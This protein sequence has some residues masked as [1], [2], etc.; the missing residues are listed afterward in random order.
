[1]NI[2]QWDAVILSVESGNWTSGLGLPSLSSV[3]LGHH[4]WTGCGAHSTFYYL[5]LGAF[6]GVKREKL[7]TL[8]ECWRNDKVEMYLRFPHVT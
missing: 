3:C 5:V 7:F 2:K 8:F 6:T 4:V 1:M